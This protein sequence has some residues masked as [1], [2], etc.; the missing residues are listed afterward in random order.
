M[1]EASGRNLWFT[2]FASSIAEE[3]IEEQWTLNFN[4]SLE[5]KLD[6]RKRAEGWKIY[7]TS[8]FA[9]FTC[10]CSNSWSSS[11]ATMVFHYRLGKKKGF[12]L[13][14]LLRQQCRECDNPI[15][16]KPQVYSNEIYQVLDRLIP[17][18]LKNCYGVPNLADIARKMNHRKTKPHESSLCEACEVGICNQS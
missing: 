9:K 3:D 15:W 6:A 13:L 11:R 5:D 12:V 2:H 7:I 8:S 1:A 17:K 10:R 16:H 18:I 14:R 4:Y